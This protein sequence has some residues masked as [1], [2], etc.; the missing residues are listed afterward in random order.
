[1]PVFLTHSAGKAEAGRW[2]EANRVYILSSP[3]WARIRTFLIKDKETQE[4]GRGKGGEG[5]GGRKEG[6]ERE[7]G[8]FLFPLFISV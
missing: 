1:M 3:A 8:L 5:E 6:V 2:F 4:G 7:E